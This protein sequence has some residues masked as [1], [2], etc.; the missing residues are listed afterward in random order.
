MYITPSRRF[1]DLIHS[2]AIKKYGGA[3]GVLNESH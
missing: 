1:I 2:F 3:D